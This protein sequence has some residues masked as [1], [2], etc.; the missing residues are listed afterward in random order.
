MDYSHQNVSFANAIL[1]ILE[2]SNLTKIRKH[3]IAE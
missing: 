2:S 3:M 1:F